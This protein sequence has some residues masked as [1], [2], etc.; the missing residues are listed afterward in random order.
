MSL[1]RAPGEQ[2]RAFSDYVVNVRVGLTTAAFRDCLLTVW[3]EWGDPKGAPYQPPQPYSCVR[4]FDVSGG[5]PN[6]RRV[7][8]GV[9]E[10]R[11]AL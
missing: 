3:E 6:D 5:C 7:G 8:A 10:L 2:G 1:N 11:E 9:E 4:V